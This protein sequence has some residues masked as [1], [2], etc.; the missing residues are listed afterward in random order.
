MKTT[1]LGFYSTSEVASTG[2][3]SVMDGFEQSWF[4]KDM[5]NGSV[6]DLSKY[7]SGKPEVDDLIF[8][9]SGA[10]GQALLNELDAL[11]NVCDP[12]S[13]YMF[14]QLNER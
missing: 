5:F 12:G 4:V 10:T 3:K 9:G 14:F 2:F 13:K 6:D 11:A 8:F 1:R 7:I